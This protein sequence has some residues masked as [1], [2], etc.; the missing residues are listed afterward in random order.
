ME[1]LGWLRPAR[2]VPV[3]RWRAASRWSP[4]PASLVVLIV[5]L[6]VFGTGEA[7]MVRAGWA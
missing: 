6:Y 3:T 7:L 5:G 2:T 1:I 4:T